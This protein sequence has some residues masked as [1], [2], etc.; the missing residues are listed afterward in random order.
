M[1][2]VCFR[3]CVA[4]A[5]AAIGG[6]VLAGPQV[7]D[8]NNPAGEVVVAEDV[9]SPTAEEADAALEIQRRLDALS[10]KDGGTLFLRAGT[11]NIRRPVVLPP[12]VTL[13][14]D[15][16]PV[17]VARSTILA[18]RCGRGEEKGTPTFQLNA[19]SGLQGLYFYYPEQGMANPIPYP[20]TVSNALKPVLT[21]EN[22]TIRDCTFLNSWCAIA[23]GPHWNELHMLSRLR[24]TA[25]K[26]GVFIDTTTD[27]GR[28][29]DVQISPRFWVESGLPGAPT[30]NDI[31][32]YLVAH[33]TVGMHIGRSDWE[34]I[35]MLKVDG[36]RVGCRFAKGVQGLSNA[37]MAECEFTSC[38]TGLEICELNRVGV[39]VYGAKFDCNCYSV[40]ATR[41]FKTV[42]QFVNCDF[43][44][45]DPV[46][47]G[48]DLSTFIVRNT[49]DKIIRHRQMAWPHPKSRALFNVADYGASPTNADNSIAFGR[50]FSAARAAGGGTVY[51]G[52]GRYSFSRGMTVPSGVELRGNAASPHHTVSGG[53]TFLV[54]SDKGEENGT[55]FIQLEAGSGIRG[56]GI[57]YPENPL[58]DP[59]PYPWAIRSLGAE[60]WIADVNIANAWQGV[61][62]QKHPSDGHRISYLSGN[63]WRRGLFVGNCKGAGWVENTQFNSHYVNRL[64]ADMPLVRGAA[65]SWFRKSDFHLASLAAQW[66]RKR[67]EAYVFRDC[68]EE[69]V[70]GSLV[71]AAM[72][73][74]SFYG[75]NNAE[76]VIHGVDT[77]ARTMVLSQEAGSTL[78]AALCQLTPYE[79]LSDK[80]S[81]GIH[82]ERGDAGV[83]TFF[84]TQVW[85]DKP[86]II[87]DGSGFARF[88]GGNSL[89]APAV[90][91]RGQFEF[92][93]FRF[94]SDYDA[95]FVRYPESRTKFVDSGFYSCRKVVEPTLLPKDLIVDYLSVRPSENVIGKYG[96]V[97]EVVSWSS[98]ISNGAF[99]FSADLK[100]VPHSNVYAEYL[101]GLSIPV[102]YRTRLKY[103]IKPLADLVDNAHVIAF[104]LHFTDGSLM[105]SS[106]NPSWPPP[107]MKLKK[108]E[109]NEICLPL[110]GSIGKTIDYMMLRVDVRNN[111]GGIRSAMIDSVSIVT[112][113]PLSVRDVICSEKTR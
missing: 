60:C 25:L 110:H 71:F 63:A 43:C 48:D 67:L 42:V 98:V 12:N 107:Q 73:G 74:M 7:V 90:L 106:P 97:H 22:Q 101:F 46:N 111:P 102:Y 72:D 64:P 45:K 32:K 10:R 14:G 70:L 29:E 81:V 55:P 51:V 82:F 38:E 92:Y 9:M 4:I 85:V 59:V 66:M 3:R 50:A 91:R 100:D 69:H 54:T 87:G 83:S 39:A 5:T 57:W 19:A 95:F 52:G 28:T 112:P 15:Y 99:L 30:E 68:G 31:G 34:N 44:G 56:L 20:W 36:Y 113:D 37:V 2:C 40:R 17:N 65:P 88:V 75:R 27:T 8:P 62:F 24:I 76:I 18:I 21:A 86:T 33:D 78:N 80:N 41:E 16:D 23:I 49:G 26:M 96:S 53:T 58:D 77:A 35:W 105:R 13:K 47:D 11:Y 61:D 89:S 109:W 1:G 94:G 93:D 6:V 104:D 108:G 79:T 84:A 103:R